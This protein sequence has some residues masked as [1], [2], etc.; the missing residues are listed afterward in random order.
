[1]KN[2]RPSQR[3]RI[4]LFRLG[5]IGDLLARD[6]AP[7]E[8]KAELLEH[9]QRRY[10]PPGSAR[11]RTYGYSTLQRWYYAAKADPLAG[12]TPASRAKGFALVLS[13][14]QRAVLLQM[15]R[16]HPSAATELLLAEA[17]RNGV[18]A[19]GALSES[20][21]RRLY[22]AA[23]LS[24]VSQKR[25]QR[26]AQP[27]RRWQAAQPGELWHGDVCHL[28]LADERGARRVVLVH[29]LLDDASRFCTALVPRAHERER[30]MLEV[31]CGALLRHPPPRV[32]YL[33]NGSCYR[34]DNLAL[35]CTRLGIR[36]VHAKPYDPEA[37]G[38][39]ERFWRSM[40]QRCT[41][42]LSPQADLQHIEQALW[43]WLDTDYHRR[44]HGGL[45]GETPRRRYL[46]GLP[47]Q[48][49]PLTPR[50]LA[51]AL[52]VALERKVRKDCTFEL[53]G[54]LYEVEG[55]HLAGQR[56]TL[57]V[58]ALTGHI[59]SAQWQDRPVRCGPC[60]PVANRGRKRPHVEQRDDSEP[61]TPFDPI[62]ALLAQARE[63]E[64]D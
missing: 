28:V 43:S 1:M 54:A 44:P 23:G 52:E 29:G 8:L 38:K 42:H 21:L 9:S 51:R 24:R 20:T 30:D 59:L 36:L 64:D 31:F 41:D 49:A 22:A 50:Q 2:L 15:R 4:A 11:A 26:N 62:A 5:I 16:E 56:I 33:D 27:R 48:R 3:E 35:L 45:L 40:R 18:L 60:D 10:R 14:E 53:D 46:D 37:R 19:Q 7:G 47:P 6:L 61:T 55:R 32:L 58:D 39:M 57:T 63:V 12:L 13:D 17:V 34:G 25:A